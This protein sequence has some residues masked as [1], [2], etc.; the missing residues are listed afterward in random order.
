MHTG[1]CCA[2]FY[3]D[4][5]G[6][7][8]EQIHRR[9]VVYTG[10]SGKPQEWYYRFTRGLQV[11]PRG[12]H[13]IYDCQ[14]VTLS[15]EMAKATG[16]ISIRPRSDSKVSGRY[17]IN[18]DQCLSNDIKPQQ[19]D[20]ISCAYVLGCTRTWNKYFAVNWSVEFKW[21]SWESVHETYFRRR[22]GQIHLHLAT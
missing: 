6:W 17:Q 11:V 3:S 20:D 9:I 16:S 15:T 12:N 10:P 19:N 13:K 22:R 18:I 21:T 4:L 7:L 14:W 5:G 8:F 2:S 1:F